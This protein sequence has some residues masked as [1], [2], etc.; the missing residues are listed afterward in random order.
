MFCATSRQESLNSSSTNCAG[1]DV[2]TTSLPLPW[3]NC[4][5]ARSRDFLAAQGT[6]QL[7]KPSCVQQHQVACVP[8]PRRPGETQWRVS[9]ELHCSKFFPG[10]HVQRRQRQRFFIEEVHLQAGATRSTL[11]ARALFIRNCGVANNEMFVQ[12][13]QRAWHEPHCQSTAGSA[14]KN[15]S[16]A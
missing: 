11:L 3:K 9:E 15:P 2:E 8:S 7:N 4:L 6:S 10:E 13:H 1:R 5:V 16:D 12:R 14:K